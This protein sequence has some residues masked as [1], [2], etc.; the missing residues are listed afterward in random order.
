MKKISL[1]LILAASLFAQKPPKPLK[2]GL[3]AVFNTELGNIRVQLF[4]KDTPNSVNAFVGLA[5]GTQSWRDPK[6]NMVKKPMY[7]NTTFY[8]VIPGDVVQG[9]SPTGETSYNCGFTIKDEILPGI[10]F[11][12]GSLAIANAGTPDTGGCQ[13]FFTTGPEH[14]F[15][16]K[17]AIIGQAVEGEDVIRK[18]SQVPSHDEHPANPPKLISVTI[19]RVGPVPVVKK[20]K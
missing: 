10:R 9:G 6:G 17:F 19:E 18:L 3:Y 11:Q 7:D 14:A 15:D 20:K 16:G 12:G 1:A 5:Q 13:F 4:E 8:R 2:P